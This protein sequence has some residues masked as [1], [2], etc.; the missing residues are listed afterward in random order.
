MLLLNGGGLPTLERC[1]DTYPG[2]R[3]NLG[4]LARPRH[5]GKLRETLDAG[6]RVGVDNDAF[7]R[8]D[9]PAFVRQVGALETAMWGAPLTWAQRVGPVFGSPWTTPEPVPDAHPNLL[10]VT[11]PDVPFDAHATARRWSEWAPLLSNFPLALC[12]QDGI[13]AVGVPWAW[14]GLACLFLAGSDE[15]KLSVEAAAVCREG[16]RRGLW[17]HAGRVN[18]RKRITYLHQ[19][20]FVD[21][22]DGSGFDMFR[23]THLPWGLQAADNQRVTQG[24]LL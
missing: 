4:R 9:L 17:I 23:D 15:F 20:G 10:F 2:G 14:P 8:W 5:C 12:V 1:R 18:S 22:F 13:G 24:V 21:S 16:K 19:L 3:V 7:S 6:F 11:V